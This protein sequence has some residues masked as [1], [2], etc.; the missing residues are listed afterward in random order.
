MS[1]IKRN[2]KQ[3]VAIDTNTRTINGRSI[4]VTCSYYT[5]NLL[6]P[7]QAETDAELL[8]GFISFDCG[9]NPE[10]LGWHLI[11]SKYVN[12]S[13]LLTGCRLAIVVDSE[14]GRLESFNSRETPYFDDH[15]LPDHIQFIYASDT[16][17]DSLPGKMIRTCDSVADKVLDEICTPSFIL[18]TPSNG[19]SLHRGHFSID[20]E[21][22]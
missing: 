20:F 15:V 13:L 19:D 9:V 18:P 21:S 1:N 3:I 10:T 5:P 2:F 14:L 8:G 16:D 12:P 22:I 6:S 17:S 4:S 11:L 7:D